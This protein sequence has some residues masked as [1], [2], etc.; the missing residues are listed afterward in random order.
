MKITIEKENDVTIAYLKGDLTQETAKGFR[1]TFKKEINHGINKLKI[2]L[3]KLAHID[4]AGYEA[5]GTV[6]AVGNAHKCRITF[7]VTEKDV[8][9]LLKKSEFVNFLPISRTK[10]DAKN[11]LYKPFKK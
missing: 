9:K 8:Y 10:K 5:M 4:D 1:E 11:Q 7:F 6:I 2:D 3:N